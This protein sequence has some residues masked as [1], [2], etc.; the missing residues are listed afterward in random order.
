MYITIHFGTLPIRRNY[1]GIVC[2]KAR[3]IATAYTGIAWLRYSGASPGPTKCVEMACLAHFW[4]SWC[5]DCLD[6]TAYSSGVYI[7]LQVTTRF[8]CR[9]RLTCTAIWT[10]PVMC[11]TGLW[12]TQISISISL[13]LK[14]ALRQSQEYPK[15]PLA[16]VGWTCPP[17]GDA[18]AIVHCF[19][20]VGGWS[21]AC[22]PS[23]E[24]SRVSGGLKDGGAGACVDDE[25]MNP[26]CLPVCSGCLRWRVLNQ[27]RNA[28]TSDCRWCHRSATHTSSSSV[29]PLCLSTTPSLF[30]SRLKPS[31]L[32]PCSSCCFAMTVVF[33]HALRPLEPFWYTMNQPGARF[34][35]KILRET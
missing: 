5:G 14:Q 15:H 10:F 7:L 28:V 23:R 11:I 22:E 21:S 16:K 17:R 25:T 18:P 29:S 12:R 4:A 27:F 30:H 20:S 33:S 19:Q 34:T 2:T 13:A 3:T 8:Y 26:S 35:K 24:S 1:P 9:N 31:R 6:V 32:P